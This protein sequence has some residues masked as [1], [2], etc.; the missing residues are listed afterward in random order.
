MERVD[1]LK[2]GLIRLLAIKTGQY[3]TQVQRGWVEG[4]FQHETGCC[5][6]DQGT[7]AV[8]SDFDGDALL[9]LRSMA[10][11]CWGEHHLQSRSA[12]PVRL[13]PCMPA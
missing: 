3:C 4:R 7:L 11:A 5:A 1:E 8:V 10:G 13:H 6:G 9:I 2:Q 12:L